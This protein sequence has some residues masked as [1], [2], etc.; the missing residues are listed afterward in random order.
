[1]PILTTITHSRTQTKC[2]LTGMDA[3][4]QN[5]NTEGP[6]KVDI[7]LTTGG[8]YFTVLHRTEELK[9]TWTIQ[10]LQVH[11]NS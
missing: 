6:E 5:E 8:T 2:S 10:L 3:H 4:Q 7:P 11:F 1:M 9:A